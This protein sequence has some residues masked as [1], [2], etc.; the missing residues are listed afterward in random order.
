MNKCVRMAPIIVGI[1]ISAPI[2]EKRGI[3]KR[4]ADNTSIA[5]P[6]LRQRVLMKTYIL[7]Y[8]I[9]LSFFTACKLDKYSGTPLVVTPSQMLDDYR[10]NPAEC[11]RKYKGKLISIKGKIDTLFVESPLTIFFPIE[12][13]LGVIANLPESERLALSR[14]RT[15]QEAS[16]LCIGNGNFRSPKDVAYVNLI[17]CKVEE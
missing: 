17:D 14:L 2:P 9:S 12:D 4:I 11:E 8:I 6:F 5:G 13:R 3:S 7:I 1:R 16:L 15:G 10:K